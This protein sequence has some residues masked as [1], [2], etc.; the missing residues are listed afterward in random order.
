MTNTAKKNNAALRVAPLKLQKIWDPVTR[1]WH[2][3]LAT[4]VISNWV[5]GE[6][7]SFDNVR[8]HFYLGYTILGLLVFRIIWGFAGPEPVRWSSLLPQPKKIINYLKDAPKRTPSGSPGHNPI[9]ALSVLALV[10]ILIA[11]ATSGLFIESDDFFESAPLVSYVSSA[12]VNSMTWWHLFLSDIL[13][14]L[15][16]LHLLAIVFY[17]VWKKENLVKPMI[18][19]WKWVRTDKSDDTSN[20]AEYD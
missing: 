9:G 7:M 11:Q 18:T 17:R 15:V 3:V 5:I 20:N 10:L 1:L 19:G 8:W 14:I 12:V 13:L 16:V 6:F 4:L 2:W